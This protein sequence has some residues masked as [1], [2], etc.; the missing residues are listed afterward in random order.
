MEDDEE[1]NFTS[2][3]SNQKIVMNET[4]AK[5]TATILLNSSNKHNTAIKENIPQN[6]SAT[7]TFDNKDNKSPSVGD[8]Q[9]AQY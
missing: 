5:E 3:S 7:K 1:L 9:A 8:I 4:L 2:L 6:K